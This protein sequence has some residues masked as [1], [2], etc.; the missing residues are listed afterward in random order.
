MATA[1][2]TPAPASLPDLKDADIA[3]MLM[4]TA[5]SVCQAIGV[6]VK[7][8][9]QIADASAKTPAELVKA[10][11]RLTMVLTHIVARENLTAEYV[12]SMYQNQ[13]KNEDKTNE[14]IS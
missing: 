5:G 9:V 12:A 13:P 7:S 6:T 8:D 14:A 3:R 4:G 2:E 11:K 1:N 10:I